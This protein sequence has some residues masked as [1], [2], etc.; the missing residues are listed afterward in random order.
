[1]I[2]QCCNFHGINSTVETSRVI[3]TDYRLCHL[4]NTVAIHIY[5][6]DYIRMEITV[7]Y[8][9]ISWHQLEIY[10]CNFHGI[11]STVEICF[12]ILADYHLRHLVN[13]V[14]IHISIYVYT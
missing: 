13:N 9:K 14:A 2:G 1:V 11:N 3:L 7:L 8:L 6:H 5:I 4:V 10:Q 12:R